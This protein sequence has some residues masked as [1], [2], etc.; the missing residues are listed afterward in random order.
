MANP[1]P[2]ITSLRLATARHCMTMVYRF[3]DGLVLTICLLVVTAPMPERLWLYALLAC[4]W[5]CAALVTMTGSPIRRGRSTAGAISAWI[6]AVILVAIIGIVSVWPT[7]EAIAARHHSRPYLHV[8]DSALQVEL[9]TRFL[10]QGRDYYALTYF[11]TELERQSLASGGFLGDI[12]I[13]PALY[14]T[15]SLPF[16][17]ELT[18]PVM[19]AARATLGWFDERFIYLACFGLVLILASMLAATASR[20]LALV[21]GLGLNPIFVPFLIGGQNDVLILAEIM[22]VLALVRYGRYRTALVL[23]GLALATKETSLFLAP[24]LLLWLAE[25]SGA[26]TWR[27]RLR[28]TA[29]LLP[30]L[31]VPAALCILPFIVWNARAFFDSTVGF[32]SGTAAHAYPIRGLGGFGFANVVLDLHWVRSM[33]DYWPFSALQVGCLLPLIGLLLYR[34]QAYRTLPAVLAAYAMTLFVA[35]YCARFCNGSFIAF[36]VAIVLLA[37]LTGQP[38][39]S[40]DAAPFCP[41]FIAFALL[42]PPLT[43]VFLNLSNAVVAALVTGVLLVYG[44]VNVCGAPWRAGAPPLAPCTKIGHILTRL[45]GYVRLTLVL[46]LLSFS[47][48]RLVT[49]GL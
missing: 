33:T 26:S 48:L 12:R 16:Q 28:A 32:V 11:H 31:L 14:H 20:R 44:L 41:E 10:L 23:L 29:V 39:P 6:R 9:A 17:E 15:D 25:R 30:W 40:G 42:V 4:Y 2:H 36:I 43:P 21:A 3:V 46:S 5:L 27:E 7:V 18:V 47:A 49:V 22:G 34:Q 38:E 35:D 45:Y 1:T 13:N 19:L 24:Y 37:S 8:G